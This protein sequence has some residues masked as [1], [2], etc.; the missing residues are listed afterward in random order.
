MARV[1]ILASGRAR[2]K[3]QP[4]NLEAV[5]L[6]PNPFTFLGL[7]LSVK[8]IQPLLH[9]SRPKIQVVP[10]WHYG[11]IQTNPFLVSVNIVVLK[12]S[13]AHSVTHCL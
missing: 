12:L 8:R 2:L 6:L 5:C 13:H 4:W 1:H 10:S 3:S 7:S 11:Q 9:F